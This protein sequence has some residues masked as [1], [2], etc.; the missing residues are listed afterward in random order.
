MGSCFPIALVES[1][2]NDEIK[3]LI[4]ERKLLI[5]WSNVFEI[6]LKR[7]SL[8]LGNVLASGLKSSSQQYGT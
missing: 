2:V 8:N 6:P 4:C 7:Y 5:E 3:I 1:M